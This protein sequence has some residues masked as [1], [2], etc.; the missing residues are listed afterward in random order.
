MKYRQVLVILKGPGG[1]HVLQYANRCHGQPFVPSASNQGSR[2]FG[3]E[4]SASRVPWEC[5]LLSNSQN[6]GKW[7]FL[8][9]W[10]HSLES[11]PFQRRHHHTDLSHLHLLR[12]RVR[13]LLLT[14][15][16]LWLSRA[17]FWLCGQM[18]SNFIPIF[19]LPL[20]LGIKFSFLEPKDL[21]LQW[22]VLSC[23]P[24]ALNR[25]VT[26]RKQLKVLILKPLFCKIGII[27]DNSWSEVRVTWTECTSQIQ[28][29]L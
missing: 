3:R 2:S 6:L 7:S 5:W 1:Q 27:Q 23:L 14:P 16:A 17:F 25:C 15:E 11:Q 22:E 26:L 10:T 28:P 13:T 8:W 18:V 21:S 19:N 24:H 29:S 9:L 4:E 12:P 20:S